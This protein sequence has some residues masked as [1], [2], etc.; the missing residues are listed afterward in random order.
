MHLVCRGCII[1]SPN[2]KMSDVRLL[3]G[4]DMSLRLPYFELSAGGMAGLRSVNA[5]LAQ[6]SLELELLELVYLRISQINGCS[7][8]LLKHSKALR[9][10]GVPQAKLDALA[11]WH[12]GDLLSERE[13]VALAWAEALTAISDSHAPD[14][15][16]AALQP[17]FSAA[18]VSDL[19]MAIA[20]MNALNR[21][22]IAMRQ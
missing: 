15:L 18:Q 16:Y 13:R 11:G 3:I 9:E 20:H 6:S 2:H 4:F 12:A 7:F 10:Q 8:C 17:H 19:T 14:E 1:P 21:L 22:A 5:Y